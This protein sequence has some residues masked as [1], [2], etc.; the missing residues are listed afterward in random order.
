MYFFL[1]VASI[2]SVIAWYLIMPVFFT[3]AAASTIF[4]A[5]YNDVSR[6][7]LDVFMEQ[8]VHCMSITEC[9]CIHRLWSDPKSVVWTRS[10]FKI[11]AGAAGTLAVLNTWEYSNNFA[12]KHHF[13]VSIIWCIS[14]GCWFL[15]CVPV[16]ISLIQCAAKE[17]HKVHPKS[18]RIGDQILDYGEKLIIDEKTIQIV[19]GEKIIVRYRS[20]MTIDLIHDIVIGIFWLYLAIMLYDLS[21]D[22]DDSEWRTIFLSMMSWHIVFVTLHHIYIKD[23]RSCVTITRSNK[24]RPCCAPSEADKWWSFTQLVGLAAIYIGFIWRM[25]EPTLTDMGCS[26]ETLGI[27]ILGVVVYYFG[28]SMHAD[29]LHGKII[30]SSK[31]AFNL[32]ELGESRLKHNLNF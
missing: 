7:D 31:H 28:K 25:K 15:S 2:T 17:V 16:L 1:A 12:T 29:T 30:D 19:S 32:R 14:I 6:K 27:I 24:S 10:G 4:I 3:F 20:C 26:S 21:D 22:E 5:T 18:I 23:I 11:L 9:C 8:S 13:I